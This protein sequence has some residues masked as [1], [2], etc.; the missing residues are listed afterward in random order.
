[1]MERGRGGA[2]LSR[3][4]GDSLST[5]SLALSVQCWCAQPAE[6]CTEQLDVV[7]IHTQLQL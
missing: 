1:M 6:T 2:S 3:L 4:P 5:T 7:N